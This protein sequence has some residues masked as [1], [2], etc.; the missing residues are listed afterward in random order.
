[1]IYL[2]RFHEFG[3]AH[4]EEKALI[5]IIPL[6]LA[7]FKYLINLHE[8]ITIMKIIIQIDKHLTTSHILA[9]LELNSDENSTYQ[10]NSQREED[11]FIPGNCDPSPGNIYTVIL[12]FLCQQS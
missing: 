2:K 6:Y 7:I 8:T 10:R 4:R 11:I 3:T 1:M 5:R 12:I 9:I